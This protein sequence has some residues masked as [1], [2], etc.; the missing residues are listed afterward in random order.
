MFSFE[1]RLSKIRGYG[2]VHV[3]STRVD[4]PVYGKLLMSTKGYQGAFFLSTNARVQS[5]PR[6][7][8]EER[9]KKN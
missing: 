1:T 7:G 3:S 5:G 8:E 4:P 2:V 9:N 6:S